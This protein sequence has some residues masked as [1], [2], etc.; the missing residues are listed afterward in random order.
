MIPASEIRPA[1]RLAMNTA[2]PD[3]THALAPKKA[4]AGLLPMARLVPLAIT[5]MLAIAT[6]L[7]CTAMSRGPVSPLSWVLSLFYGCALWIWWAA[8][9][10]AL[11]RAGNRWP[12]ASRVSLKS[13]AIQLPIAVGIILLHLGLLQLCIWWIAGVGPAGLRSLR[14]ITIAPGIAAEYRSLD[15]FC[16]PRIGLE[17][18]IYG[19]VWFACS[20]LQTQLAAR[21]DAMH[22]L[23]LERQ[24]SNA[25]L[26]ALQMQLEP[27]FLFNTLNAVTT[28]MEL[29]RREE[30]LETLGHLNTILKTVL[31]RD[32][33]SKIP[34]VQEM[35]IVES[36]LAIERVR[37]A[38]R[39]RVDLNLDPGALDGLVPS[40]LLQPIVENAIR[41]G[42]AHC[43]HEGCIETS[44]KRIGARMHLQ[45]RDNGPGPN[46]NGNVHSGFGVG[47]LNTRERLNHFYQDDYEL[48]TSQ[49]E[50]GG[51]EVSITIP[52]E[53][54]ESAVS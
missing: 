24:L 40:F 8:V 4:E 34:L 35:E 3:A 54:N 43:Q 17:L 25:H 19:L 47:L 53:E 7:E 12:L 5:V 13:F 29:N 10:E 50:S 9:V 27:H 38:D 52:Y 16:L 28:L 1:E 39:L 41:H 15:V 45:V 31:K 23:E 44:A 30:A 14:W 26:R 48:R 21:R 42:I 37:F 33:P 6:A 11:W 46:G 51:F 36:Y 32:T 49:P 2:S 20:A 18:L 22:S